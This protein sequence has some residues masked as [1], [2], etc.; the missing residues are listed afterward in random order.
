MH[1]VSPLSHTAPHTNASRNPQK[2]APQPHHNTPTALEGPHGGPHG[3]NTAFTQSSLNPNYIQHTDPP[4]STLT[5]HKQ[6]TQARPRA[7]G[8]TDNRA[9]RPHLGVV[10]HEAVVRMAL[11]EQA[12]ALL[13]T[14]SHPGDAGVRIVD[15]VVSGDICGARTMK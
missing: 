14:H 15:V 8:H 11:R 12:P 10:C 4:S 6:T 5:T 2:Q 9:K 7:H 1:T 3:T 13:G